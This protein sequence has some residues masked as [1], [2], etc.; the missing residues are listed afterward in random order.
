MHE[1]QK[2]ERWSPV[3]LCGGM[4]WALGEFVG[5]WSVFIGT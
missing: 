2:L 4:D 3:L 5:F 1:E